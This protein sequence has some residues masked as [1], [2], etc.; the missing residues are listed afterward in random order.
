MVLWLRRPVL[1]GIITAFL[2]VM[3]DFTPMHQ[4]GRLF[5]VDPSL[6]SAAVDCLSVGIGAAAAAGACVPSIGAIERRGPLAGGAVGGLSCAVVTYWLSGTLAWL[7]ATAIAL[8]ALLGIAI[9][10][11]FCATW[12]Y[13]RELVA[14]IG[15]CF[16]IATTVA[17][18]PRIE[19]EFERL[20]PPSP[21]EMAEMTSRTTRA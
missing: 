11:R 16:A 10:L 1:A 7:S 14:L 3:L 12:S 15:V 18:L 2:F 13:R 20:Y 19:R 21:I 9:A 8:V 5:G 17:L 6:L 4:P